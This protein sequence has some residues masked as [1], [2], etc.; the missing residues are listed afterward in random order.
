MLIDGLPG[1]IAIGIVATVGFLMV[2]A[3]R[4][5]RSGTSPSSDGSS[6]SYWSGSS[7]R[8]N[9]RSD[10]SGWFSGLFSPSDSSSSCHDSGSSSDSGRNSDSG[11]SDS[12]GGDSSGGGGDGGGG[13]GD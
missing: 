13:G 1:L 8:D 11:S 2:R 5:R 6:T 3:F 10:S 9:D 4:A 7:S 12:G